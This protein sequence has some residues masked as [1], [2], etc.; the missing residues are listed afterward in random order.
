MQLK[1]PNRKLIGQKMHPKLC[2]FGAETLLY[3]K[4]QVQKAFEGQL[5]EGR[6]S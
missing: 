2:D 6:A 5:S 3:N 1:K 4:K